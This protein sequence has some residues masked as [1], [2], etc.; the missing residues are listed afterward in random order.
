MHTK[1]IQFLA[2]SLLPVAL[3][4]GRLQ[5]AHHAA[6][7]VAT[8]KADKS[9]VTVADQESEAIILEALARIAPGVAVV[10]EEAASAGNIPVVGETFFLVDPLD[11]TR[12]FLRRDPSFTIN[13]A[14]I[15]DRSPAFGLLYAPALDDFYVT[16]GPGQ[17][18]A[19]RLAPSA[20]P[21]TLAACAL[22]P[23][24]TRVPDPNALAALTSEIHLDRATQRFLDRYPVVERRQV[25]SSLKFGLM[26]RGE[27]DIYPRAG[28]TSEWDTAAGHAVLAAAGGTVTTFDGAP[29]L[30][31]KP[32][33]RN[34]GFIAW[35]RTPLQPQRPA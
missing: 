34:H 21:G 26:A 17:A 33:F 18:C 24:R 28:D 14:L 20:E 25:S 7:V 16:V 22:T 12:P 13:V 31:G 30:Y 23:L 8:K 4:V 9:P 19:A 3:R 15:E 2:Q 35:G 27:A 32:G 11:G 10:S 1:D 29:L 5:M 6:G